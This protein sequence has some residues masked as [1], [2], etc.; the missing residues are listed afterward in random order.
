MAEDKK[1]EEKT[2]W[3]KTIDNATEKLRGNP[4][5]VSTIVLGVLCVVLFIITLQPSLTGNT[6]SE[7]KA[8]DNLISFINSRGEGT[9]EL[10]S[11]K[12]EGALYRAVVNYNE[13]DIPVFVSL[14]GGFL[15][16]S[17]ISLTEQAIPQN[18]AEEPTQ[19][20]IPKSDKP[21]VEL[22]VMSYCPYGTQAEKGIIPAVQLL[23]DKIDFKL[24]FVH[25]TMH[26]EKEDTENNRQMCIREE[27]SQEKLNN[28]IMCIMDSEDSS[29][30]ADVNA[31]EKKAGID[32][33]KLNSCVATKAKDY[34][35]IDSSLSEQYG[36]GGS[37]TLVINGV[38]S[39]AG[40]SSQSYL[41]GICD[42]FNTAPGECSQTL[43]GATPS[44]GFGLG[45]SDSNTQASC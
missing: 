40:R 21:V 35:A 28:Y 19:Q 31:C 13:Q 6:V 27:Q 41:Q 3:S 45:S 1:I 34:Y 16:P 37:P 4:W 10:V 14:D 30:P 36:V 24:R 15:M 18:Q 44:P 39:S 11:I 26:G 29:A 17:A 43:S 38:Q 8:G 5:M 23:K 2:E 20:E 42:A 9:A 22:F 33:N 12:K 32:S 25:Y 7:D